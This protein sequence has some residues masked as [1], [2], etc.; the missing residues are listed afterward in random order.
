MSTVS[1]QRNPAT[2]HPASIPMLSVSQVAKRLNC[3]L[4]TVYALVERRQLEHYRCPGIR[5]SEEQLL[6]Y[7]ERNKQ[8]RAPEPPKRQPTTRPRLRHITLS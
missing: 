2:E 8:G 4:S 7:L 1:K 3:S 5:V 6:A